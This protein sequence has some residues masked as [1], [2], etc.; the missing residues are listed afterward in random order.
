MKAYD[1]R[2]TMNG[3]PSWVSE[4]GEAAFW[5]PEPFNDGMLWMGRFTGQSPWE[6]HPD[7]DEFIHVLEGEVEVTMLADD[8]PAQIT[9]SA[10]S[11]FIVPRG[12][13]HKQ[14]ASAEVTQV[15]ATP[16][17]TE[18]SELEDPRMLP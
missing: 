1:I 15:G 13:W 9:V 4:G 12:L 2:S 14:V 17:R 6:R 11:V 16:G 5:V 8:G 10:G 3:T 7:G 18:H